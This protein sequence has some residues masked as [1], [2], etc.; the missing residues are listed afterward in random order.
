M[1]RA[2]ETATVESGL[3]FSV[4]LGDVEEETRQAAE[5]LLA[6]LGD[7]AATAVLVVLA[8]NHRQLEIVT[9][10]RA[11]QRLSDRACALVSLSMTTSFAGGD[12]VGGLVNGLRM[13]TDAAGRLAV[14]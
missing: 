9:G 5:R 7:R 13:L 4:F 2:V 11:R 10:P 14:H 6:A 3:H 8:P 12:L 1:E